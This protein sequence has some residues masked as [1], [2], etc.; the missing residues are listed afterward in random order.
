MTDIQIL[1]LAAGKGSR[2]KSAKPKVLHQVAGQSMLSH[3]IN[4]ANQLSPKTLHAIVG[5]GADQIQ[6]AFGSAIEYVHQEEQL[7]TGHAV[8]QAECE[9]EDESIVL[10]LYGDVPLV[11]ASTLS[12]VVRKADGCGLALLTLDMPEPTGYGRIVRDDAK[13]IS[14]IVEHKDATLEQ[15]QIKEVNTGILAARGKLLK[16]WL[17][18]LSNDNASGEY[19]LTDIVAMAVNGGISVDAV[20][21]EYA[22]EV[23]GA[24]SRAQL[25]QMERTYQRA[26]AERLLDAGATI[27]DPARFDLR[28]TLKIGKDVSIDVNAIFEGDVEL[29]DGV[30]IG[31]HTVIKDTKISDNVVVKPF[32]HIESS[33]IGKGSHIGPYARLREGTEL[34]TDTKIGNFV[35]TKKVKMKDGAKA[36]HLTYLGD[37]EIGEATNIGAGTITCNYDGE[38]KYKTLIGKKTFVGSNTA[39]VAPVT[40]ADD[41]TVAAGSVVTKDVEKDN[42]AIARARQKNIEGWQKKPK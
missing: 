35:E 42:L 13:I 37:A 8:K 14:G 25:A 34:G 2:M 27:V 39:I 16:N 36:S 30:T 12:A 11:Q 18:Q 40:I 31:A 32:S 15:R 9:I 6:S 23:D 22:W 7:G 19:Y 5:F 26:L 10:V 17:C 28:G 29:G 4:S 38:N 21:P 33:V 3:V 24:N 1:I 20:Q 41:A